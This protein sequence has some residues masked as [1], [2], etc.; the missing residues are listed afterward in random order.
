MQE[1][2]RQP[3]PTTATVGQNINRF[4]KGAGHTL[5]DLAALVRAQGA[6]MSTTVV[7]QIENGTRRID[8]DDLSRFAYALRVPIVALLAPAP[9]DPAEI[10][11]TS[12]N[13]SDTAETAIWRIFGEIPDAPTWLELSIDEASGAD[14]RHQARGVQTLESA[15]AVFAPSTAESVDREAIERAALMVRGA[16]QKQY[17]ENAQRRLETF[18]DTTGRTDGQ[19]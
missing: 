16:I 8:V 5:K 15:I 2:R 1:K 14:L 12:A 18:A 4:R 11:G 9:N 17:E 3:E 10:V 13:E 7:S 19:G 6:S